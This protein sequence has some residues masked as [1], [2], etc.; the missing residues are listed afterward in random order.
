MTDNKREELL[1]KA[2][3]MKKAIEAWNRRVE[4]E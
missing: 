4:N 3:P 1:L 2:K